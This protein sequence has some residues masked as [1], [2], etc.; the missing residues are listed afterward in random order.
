MAPNASVKDKPEEK[1]FRVYIQAVLSGL[2]P[3]P[4]WIR[5]QMVCLDPGGQK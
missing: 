1:M 4:D 3:H 5:I 2:D